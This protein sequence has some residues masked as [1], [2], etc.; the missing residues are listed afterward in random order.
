MY[1]KI[2]VTDD[3]GRLRDVPTFQ[4]QLTRFSLELW[5]G[6]ILRVPAK[7]GQ[8]IDLKAVDCTLMDE[9]LA[10]IDPANYWLSSQSS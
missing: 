2:V 6:V 4:R 9:Q 3:Q 10:Q 7:S 8:H 5:H 1:A